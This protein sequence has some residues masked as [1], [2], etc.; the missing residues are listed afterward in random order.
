VQDDVSDD[1]VAFRTMRRL[2]AL[3]HARVDGVGIDVIVTDGR[4]DH[5]VREVAPFHETLQCG[6]NDVDG[7]D[8]E[9]TSE[10]GAVIGEA[11]AIGAK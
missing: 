4:G 11:E 10:G 1:G 3:R 7:I 5:V 9:M 6:E 2:S 8:F